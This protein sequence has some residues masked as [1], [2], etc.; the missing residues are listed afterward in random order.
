MSE[1]RDLCSAIPH[2][3]SSAAK[4]RI[5]SLLR[6]QWLPPSCFK[7]LALVI[8]IQ[9]GIFAVAQVYGARAAPLVQPLVERITGVVSVEHTDS[10]IHRLRAFADGTLT[11]QYYTDNGRNQIDQNANNELANTIAIRFQQHDYDDLDVGSGGDFVRQTL[12]CLDDPSTISGY[13]EDS[14]VAYASDSLPYRV[15]QRT[16]TDDA[17]DNWVVM[18]FTIENTN[19]DPSGRDLTGGKMLFMLD[20]DV[21]HRDIDDDGHWNGDRRL[22]YQVDVYDNVWYAMGISLGRGALSGYGVEE[23]NYLATDLEK[24]EEMT[25]DTRQ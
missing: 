3:S 23:V 17:P 15:T 6:L 12:I 7:L 5:R 19:G 4:R 11:N 13:S 9:G 1:H 8:L 21:A 24:I 25:S 14:C 16:F 20:I 18:E 22:V 10:T 2:P